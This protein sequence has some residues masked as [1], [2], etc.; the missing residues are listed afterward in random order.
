M[1]DL[2]GKKMNTIKTYKPKEKNVQKL[3]AFLKKIEHGRQQD[4]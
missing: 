1:G 2:A 3:K 4:K